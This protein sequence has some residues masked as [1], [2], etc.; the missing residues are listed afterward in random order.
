MI[1]ASS[2][3][4]ML[5]AILHCT[6]DFLESGPSTALGTFISLSLCVGTCTLFQV[7]EYAR[8]LKSQLPFLSYLLFGALFQDFQ[9]SFL[10]S[11][12]GFCLDIV[13][14]T[15]DD[16]KCGVGTHTQARGASKHSNVSIAMHDF[17]NNPR[18]AYQRM[19][20][21]D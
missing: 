21:R 10:M 11:S 16:V 14:S 8:L 7:Y 2:S 15:T 3:L 5:E 17:I 20:T 4:S 19:I 18:A 9:V 12:P 6:A 13:D 1:E